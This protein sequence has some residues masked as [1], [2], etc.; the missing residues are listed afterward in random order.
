MKDKDLAF[1]LETSA[2]TS[3]NVEIA[4]AEAAKHIILKKISGNIEKNA[5]LRPANR[6]A[7]KCEC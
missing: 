7:K 1:M 3:E 5:S 2:K 4:F 6:P